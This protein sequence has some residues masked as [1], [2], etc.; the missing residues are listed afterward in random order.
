MFR[1]LIRRVLW[2]FPV[3]LFIS[4]ITFATAHAVRVG[5]SRVNA[6]SLPRSSPIWRQ[7][8]DHIGAILRGLTLDLSTPLAVAA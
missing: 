8:A 1:Y 7:Y 5:R 3:L 4:V 2:L 6:S